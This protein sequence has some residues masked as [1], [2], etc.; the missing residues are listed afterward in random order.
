LVPGEAA[1]APRLGTVMD[2]TGNSRLAVFDVERD[3]GIGISGGGREGSESSSKSEAAVLEVNLDDL[4]NSIFVRKLELRCDSCQDL[5][6]LNA[7]CIEK[8]FNTREPTSRQPP[9]NGLKLFLSQPARWR[10]GTEIVDV[11]KLLRNG[12][13]TLTADDV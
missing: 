10:P 5:S 2:S 7:G 9:W 11:L 3:I 1:V 12:A 13:H 8:L 6:V 4:G